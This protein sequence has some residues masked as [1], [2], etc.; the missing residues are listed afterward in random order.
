MET[1]KL[2]DCARPIKRGGY[3]YGH[4]MKNWRYGTPEPEHPARFDDIAGQ[5]FGTLT[6]VERK[7]GKWLCRCDCGNERLASAGELNR[8]GDANTCGTKSNHLSDNVGYGAA[9]D[10]V[11]RLHGPADR[12]QCVDCGSRAQHW[13]YDHTDPD[14]RYE[15]GLS[16]RPVAYSLDVE[17]YSP[18]CVPCHKRYDL[19]RANSTYV[20]A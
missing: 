3:C 11:K 18:R 10:R 20:A 8:T 6:A 19:A 14:E 2:E 1:C 5:R 4:Y 9:H 12:H 17:H 7:Q 16:A 13:S 15:E